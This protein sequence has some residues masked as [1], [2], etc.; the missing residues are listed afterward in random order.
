M[1]DKRENQAAE[2]AEVIWGSIPFAGPEY[3]REPYVK[4]F[5]AIIRKKY[6]NRDAAF[7]R[8][9]E[10]AEEMAKAARKSCP[11]LHSFPVKISWGQMDKLQQAIDAAKKELGNDG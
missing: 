8:L 9:V 11:D 2:A 5:A 1:I 10:A 7:R 4:H 3:P 6:T